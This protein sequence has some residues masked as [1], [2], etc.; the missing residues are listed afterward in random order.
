MRLWNTFGVK[1]LD[2]KAVLDPRAAQRSKSGKRVVQK[3]EK[4]W[5]NFEKS[6]KISYG[7]P[8]N[9]IKTSQKPHLRLPK[10]RHD[11]AQDERVFCAKFHCICSCA[12]QMH[13]ETDRMTNFLEYIIDMWCTNLF[14]N[15]CQNLNTCNTTD[16][17]FIIDI[18]LLSETIW[19]KQTKKLFPFCVF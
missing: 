16:N 14:I 18:T 7:F 1:V 6:K 15:S 3:S 8:E 9:W 12:V 5:K 13:S 11:L 4:S 17:I 2:Q 10:P 19:W